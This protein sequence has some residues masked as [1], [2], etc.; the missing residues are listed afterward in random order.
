MRTLS[1]IPLVCIF[2][3]LF[4]APMQLAAQSFYEPTQ[5]NNIQLYFSETNWDQILDNLA[6]AGQEERLTGN[7]I[8][9]G[10]PYDSVGVRYK[11]NSS[12]NANRNKNPFNIKLDYIYDDQLIDVVYGTIKLA[13]GFNDPSLIRETLA[14]EIARKY[15]PA[16]LA[17]YAN[18]YVNGILIGVYTSVQDVDSYFMRTHLGCTGKPRFKSDSN[19]TGNPVIWGYNGADSTAYASMYEIE[20]DYG[21]GDLIH[22][23]NVLNNDQTSV[24]NVLNVDQHLWFLAFENLL[25]NFDS[26]INIFHNFYL[27]GDEDSR[28]NP[29]LWDLNEAFGTFNHVGTSNLTITQLQNY[30]PLAN[31]TSPIHTLISKVLSNPRYKKMY[32]AHMRTM[33]TENFSNGWY[34]TRGAEL[35]NICAPYV[36]ADPNF[37]YT[38][39]NFMAN[40]NSNITGPRTIPGITLLMNTRATFLQNNSAFAGTL[41]QISVL[42]YSPVSPLPNTTVSFTLAALDAN[43]AQLG[44]RQNAAQK[45]NYYQM[46]DDGMHSDG[47][48]GDGV[49]GI[50][51]PIGYGNVQYYAWVENNSQ[52]AFYP[53]RAEH[54]FFSINVSSPQGGVQ[55]NEIN[56]NSS[57]DF[58]PGD[59][60][61]IHNPGSEIIDI[62]NW[63]FK[64]GDDS[65]SFSIPLGTTLHADE[66]LV[67]CQSLAEFQ[68][69]FPNV[70]NVLGD[71][72]FGLSGSG[73]PV[74]LYTSSGEVVDSVFYGVNA[75]WP[76]E[77]NGTGSTLALISPELDNNL[78]ESW[79][80]SAGNGSPGAS[81]S[82]SA[83]E[84]NLS[85]ALT[86]ALSSYPNPFSSQTTI[87]YKN[88]RNANLELSIYNLKGQKVRTLVSDYLGK[89]EHSL[90]WDGRDSH[91][92]RLG[93][94]IYFLVM[95]SEGASTVHKMLLL[96]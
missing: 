3:A 58:D 64:D 36:Q 66:Y 7:A 16:S 9:N 56:Y 41:P 79:Q 95:Q 32:I 30:D 71:F 38:Y 35:Q 94:G 59:W 47:A 76:T 52:G 67:L 24:A 68:T 28:F 37:F 91:N 51:V 77:P 87:Q 70:T 17:N 62:S 1:I 2:T 42:N 53:A 29:I 96:K 50:S 6:A 74:R 10:V 44:I 8:I 92:S 49:F 27:F 12:Y 13:N 72:D 90:S 57:D 46:F 11:G 48:A 33:L 40:L 15:M 80:A 85:P 88:S 86:I 22:F 81:N 75:P 26:P 84:D 65:H 34:A 54:E 82:G 18:V 83:I 78:P 21:W 93:S 61:E 5:V 4:F 43:Y 14:Y 19:P 23:T 55:F 89:G 69:W 45:F 31:L 63:V 60:V 73:E 39:A 20:S 25:D